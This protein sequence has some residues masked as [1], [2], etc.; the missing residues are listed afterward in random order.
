MTLTEVIGAF[1]PPPQAAT[2]A[3]TASAATF[4]VHRAMIISPLKIVSS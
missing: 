2:K 3:A 1:S 4:I